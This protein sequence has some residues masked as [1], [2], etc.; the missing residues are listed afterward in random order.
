MM[1]Y[2]TNSAVDF[3]ALALETI[4][5]GKTEVNQAIQISS[6]VQKESQR[7]H[8]YLNTLALFGF[9]QWLGG[10]DPE[11]NIERGK[12][13]IFQPSYINVIAAVFNLQVGK[14]KLCLMAR[15]SLTD[16]AIAFPRA[17]IDLPEFVAHFYVVLEV[18]EELE[19]VRIQ[20]FIRYDE[21]IEQANKVTLPAEIDWT[22]QLPLAWFES[23]SDKLLLYLRCLAPAAIAL[24]SIPQ[25]TSAVLPEL[26]AKFSQLLPQLQSLDCEL[27][28]VF[29]WE[30]GATLLTNTELLNKLV[31]IPAENPVS[32]TEKV[33]Q[34]IK[35]PI[36]NV[37]RWLQ[38]EMDE[39][40]QQLDWVLLPAFSPEVVPLRS[41]TQELE[42]ILQQ[43]ERQGINIPMIARG[44]YQDFQLAKISLRL[45]AVTWT[46]S[47]PKNL[48][49]WT[50]LL[51]LGAQPGTTIH[52]VLKLLLSD[53]TGVL[54]ERVLEPHTEETYI[55]AQVVG[56]WE[57]EFNVT[58]TSPETS[59]TLP[60]FA[61]RP[62]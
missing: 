12:C 20:G 40:T 48:P 30:E 21:L 25:Q 4:T 23:N 61:F 22:Y 45:Y 43:L 26:Q 56:T 3:E 11:I 60:A 37:G 33:L 31:G 2:D 46:C 38:D 59:L 32:P 42:A 52:Q 49:E 13:S 51:I 35:E 15:G 9:E 8:I 19:Q 6:Q 7:W 58:I 24:P 1:N 57:E 14:F 36:V 47:S 5:L 44:A 28:E 39:F 27:W 17:V 29:P 16:E 53:E 34:L 41:P 55:Y 50:L 54:L 10:R 18:T 62:N